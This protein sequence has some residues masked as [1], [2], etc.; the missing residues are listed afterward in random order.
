M[1]PMMAHDEDSISVKD[2][3]EDEP[4]QT[5]SSLKKKWMASSVL[6]LV[7][8]VYLFAGALIFSAL[9]RPGA[10]QASDDFD[11]ALLRLA[12]ENDCLDEEDVAELMY[13]VTKAIGEGAYASGHPYASLMTLETDNETAFVSMWSVQSNFVFVTSVVTTVGR[14]INLFQTNKHFLMYSLW[15]VI[16]IPVAK[17]CNCTLNGH[18]CCTKL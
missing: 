8:L 6:L 10:V 11:A 4:Q 16:L 5:S 13:I 15:R 14:H 7:I 17:E 2:I 3:G 12:S 9:E 1:Q 18:K